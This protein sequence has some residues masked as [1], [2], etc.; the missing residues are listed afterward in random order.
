MT[1]PGHLPRELAPD[2]F[3]I[4][5]CLEQPYRGE[6]FHGYNSSYLIVGEHSCAL[7]EAGFPPDL[8]V[9]DQQLES[10]LSRGLP[11]LRYVFMTHQ[12]TP[13]SS[14]LGRLL[15]RYPTAVA[16]G[17]VSDFHLVFPQFAD[18][19]RSLEIGE[20]IDLGGTEL[21]VVDPVIRDLNTTLWAFDTSRRVL[22][23]GDGFA[24]SHYHRDGHC[25]CLAEEADSLDIPDMTALF[26]ELALHWTTF[27]DMTPFVRRLEQLVLEELEVEMI[28]PT[29][30]LP[31]ADVKGTLPKI[32]EGLFLGSGAVS[33]E[34][35]RSPSA[36]G[37]SD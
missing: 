29:H 7:I 35:A 5:D 8:E 2:L 26:A 6:I 16:C 11:E 27:H 4:G 18:R 34:M 15:E 10:L 1:N 13:H 12:E 25:G 19:L 33:A 17:D 3:W 32:I 22:F 30:G 37:G 21:V 20:S 14:G 28:A 9:L 31:I 36:H 24:Y 23:P